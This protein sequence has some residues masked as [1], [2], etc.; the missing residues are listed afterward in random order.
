M[1]DSSRGVQGVSSA[2]RGNYLRAYVLDGAGWD[3]GGVEL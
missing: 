3:G 1:R 2:R